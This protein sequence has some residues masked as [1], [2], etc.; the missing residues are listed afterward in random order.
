M[1]FLSR[2][3]PELKNRSCR[4]VMIRM[5]SAEKR[6]LEAIGRRAAAS[7][8]ILIEAEAV[9]PPVYHRNRS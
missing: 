3:K 1:G 2:Y 9:R 8:E 5:N 6:S 7:R 4:G